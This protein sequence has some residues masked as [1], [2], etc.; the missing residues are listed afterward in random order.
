MTSHA[1][2]CLIVCSHLLLPS[3]CDRCCFGVCASWSDCSSSLSTNLALTS[4]VPVTCCRQW[5]FKTPKR[6]RI[7]LHQSSS[8]TWCAYNTLELHWTATNYM[9]WS[10]VYVFSCFRSQNSTVHQSR[11]VA[12]IVAILVASYWSELTWSRTFTN[13][14]I[15]HK[16]RRT[17]LALQ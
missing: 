12:W 6:T 5:R 11:S 8:L 16:P 4:N 7:S 2:P 10:I 3:A 15:S 9:I 14:C 1:P 17:D 13:S